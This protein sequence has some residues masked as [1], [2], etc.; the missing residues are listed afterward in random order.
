MNF[1][2]LVIKE[3]SK[4]REEIFDS[5]I[6]KQAI[7]LRDMIDKKILEDLLKQQNK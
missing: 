1:K 6:K 4:R 3:K 7:I 2:K 5:I